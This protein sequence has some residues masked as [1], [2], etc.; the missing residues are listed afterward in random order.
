[1]LKFFAKI[2]KKFNITIKICK[3]FLSDAVGQRVGLVRLAVW[4]FFLCQGNNPAQMT[5]I[6]NDEKTHYFSAI[7]AALAGAGAGL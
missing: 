4:V 1:M 3:F 6:A 7:P 2:R 5:F